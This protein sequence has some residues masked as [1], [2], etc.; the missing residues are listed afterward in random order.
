V[1][2]YF[3]GVADCRRGRQPDKLLKQ[4]CRR[5]PGLAAVYTGKILKGENHSD[6]PIQQ[7]A[8]VELAINLKTAKALGLTVPPALL[9]RADEVFG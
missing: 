1:W 5:S 6:I 9:A 8:K 3:K 2:R 7:S 4:R